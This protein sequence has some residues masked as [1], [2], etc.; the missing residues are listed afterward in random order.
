MNEKKY[1]PENGII[2]NEKITTIDEMKIQSNS[3]VKHSLIWS[4]VFISAFILIY[5]L[6]RLFECGC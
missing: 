3:G 6:A 4:S 2:E 5:V 1:N